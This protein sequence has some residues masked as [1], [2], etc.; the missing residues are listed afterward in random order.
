MQRIGIL[1]YGVISYLV[2]LVTMSYLVLFVGDFPA[3]KTVSGVALLPFAQALTI[4]ILLVTLFGLQHSIMARAWFKR[5][6]NR[7]LPPGAERTTFVLASSMVFI[8]MMAFWQPMDGVLWQAE[9]RVSRGLLHVMFGAG[10]ILLLAA[11][12]SI[13]HW[14]LFG[15]RQIWCAYR[16]LPY[17]PPQF[18][19]PPLYRLVRHPL[20]LGFCIAVWSVPTMTMENFVFAL[21]TSIYVLIGI[22]YEECDLVRIHGPRYRDYQRRVPM[23]VPFIRP[24]APGSS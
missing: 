21:A 23:L 3:P 20:Y 1:L 13:D 22:R 19:D 17:S 6:I 8:V 12:F 5:R 7:L 2:F 14:D 4:N 15:L 11:T 24:R 16:H 9:S 10:W 18:K